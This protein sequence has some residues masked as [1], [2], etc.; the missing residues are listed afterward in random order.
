MLSR[1]A[2]LGRG[3]QKRLARASYTQFVRAPGSN[4]ASRA[5]IDTAMLAGASAFF[6]AGVSWNLAE[7]AAVL[8]FEP[9]DEARCLAAT[10]EAFTR[11]LMW[12]DSPESWWSERK[13][14][15]LQ[16]ASEATQFSKELDGF[17]IRLHMV[18]AIWE[19]AT[20]EELKALAEANE[21]CLKLKFD[22][23]LESFQNR[24]VFADGQIRL[25]RTTTRP[26]LMGLIS[27]REVDSILREWRQLPDGRVMQ[28]GLGLQ[29]PYFAKH[30][31]GSP[32]LEHLH[33]APPSS[34][35]V[36]AVD[37]CSGFV[38]EPLDDAARQG[39]QG[40]WKISYVLQSEAGGGVPRWVAEKAVPKAIT[41]WFV[42]AS[43][44]LENLRTEPSLRQL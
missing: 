38:V 11:L 16:G 19:S 31:L 40:R 15:R 26:T 8:A 25:L 41:D 14:I 17:E 28:G 18:T 32:A 29:S 13:K 4:V 44:E 2:G 12:V 39:G 9:E 5:D 22:P 43:K 7:E 33:Q 34:G 30:V 42:S 10:D 35:R 37:H 24:S 23:I 1:C 27:A 6:L 36:R 21:S 3:L 20:I